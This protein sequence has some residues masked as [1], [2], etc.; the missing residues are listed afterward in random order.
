M[1]RE[2]GWSEW[3]W[4][5]GLWDPTHTEA[6][7]YRRYLTFL[8]IKFWAAPQVMWGELFRDLMEFEG[9]LAFGMGHIGLVD[10]PFSF[11]ILDNCPIW[12]RLIP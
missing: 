5:F 4:E 10:M 3:L 7:A 8:H 12:E 6:Q 1:E 9:S 11:H 2:E